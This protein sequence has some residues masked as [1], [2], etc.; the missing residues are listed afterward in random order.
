MS[1]TFTTLDETNIV[2]E[3][4]PAKRNRNVTAPT[5]WTMRRIDALPG[6][7]NNFVCVMVPNPKVSGKASANWP[8][9]G[10]IGKPTV[11]V[12]AYIAAYPLADGGVTRAERSLTWD[13]D[14]GYIKI[15]TFDG[16]ADAPAP[17]TETGFVN[18]TKA[19][20]ETLHKSVAPF[21][22]PSEQ[23]TPYVYGA[24]MFG[25]NAG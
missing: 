2:A 4:R 3:T 5:P 9:Y 1:A 19:N 8:L 7:R 22:P 24:K 17:E 12:A 6:A 25:G 13:L 21:V 14:R 10:T 18:V 11:T 15:V 23:D 20:L 16:A